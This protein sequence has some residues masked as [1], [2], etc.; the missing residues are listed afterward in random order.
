[1]GGTIGRGGVPFPADV[2]QTIEKFLGVK[3]D[4]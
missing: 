1:M 3:F 4:L 2:T